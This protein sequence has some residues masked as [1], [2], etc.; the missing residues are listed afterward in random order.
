MKR[1]VKLAQC[2]SL[3]CFHLE[4]SKQNFT[5]TFKKSKQYNGGIFFYIKG[6]S[7]KTKLAH[8]T[9]FA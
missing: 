8:F 3:F 9:V 6:I 1:S 2:I 5:L 7:P 4:V